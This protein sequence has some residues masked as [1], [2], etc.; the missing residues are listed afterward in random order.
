MKPKQVEAM[1]NVGPSSHNIKL[2][3]LWNSK[4]AG[5]QCSSIYGKKPVR[6]NTFLKSKEYYNL[7]SSL[8]NISNN[9]NSLIQE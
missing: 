5:N 6:L 7:T 4:I 3:D 2:S 8:K 1:Q 9:Q